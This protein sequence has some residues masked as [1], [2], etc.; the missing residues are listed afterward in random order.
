MRRSFRSGPS[1]PASIG[2]SS[3][4]R[5][6]R[7][8]L[9]AGAL[10]FGRGRLGPGWQVTLNVAELAARRRRATSGGRPSRSRGSRA[11]G[12]GRRGASGGSRRSPWA[13]RRPSGSAPRASAGATSWPSPS[14]PP[15]R[16]SPWN[17]VSTI[18]GPS[19]AAMSR[20]WAVQ[21]TRVERKVRIASALCSRSFFSSWSFSVGI[22]AA[23][24]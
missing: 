4:G 17:D 10:A 14:P 15:A 1:R 9:A 6:L 3:P 12:A 11:S 20:A 19:R 23:Q 16:R 18:A 22:L 5:S 21:R 8:A 13:W 24:A 2:R 7:F